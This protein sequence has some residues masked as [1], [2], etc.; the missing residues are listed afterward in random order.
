MIGFY[1]IMIAVVALSASAGYTIFTSLTAGNALSLSH[2]NV[3]LLDQ[4]LAALQHVMI[5][6]PEGDVAIPF[7]DNLNPVNPNSR[8]V[9]PSWVSGQGVTPWNIPYGYC[10]YAPTDW[11]QSPDDTGAVFSATGVSYT[12]DLKTD[13]FSLG[14]DRSYVIGGSSRPSHVQ[15]APNP[16]TVL[17]F[18][19]SP[20]AN[21]SAVPSCDSIYWTGTGWAVA[22]SPSGAVRALTKDAV[23]DSLAR[24]P[25]VMKRY[26]APVGTGSGRFPSEPISLENALR[27]FRLLSPLRMSLEFSPGSY[28]I[29]LTEIDFG[30]GAQVPTLSE[31]NAFQ[32]LKL[33][34]TG[35]VEISP[36]DAGTLSFPIDTSI[37]NIQF[38]EDILLQQGPGTRLYMSDSSAGAIHS[39]GAYITLSDS[40][41]LSPQNADPALLIEGGSA[42]I[43]GAV[44]IDMDLSG[45]D[46]LR[47]SSGNLRL[48]G[49]LFIENADRLFTQD[50]TGFFQHGPSAS[51]SIDTIPETLADYPGFLIPNLV[52]GSVT[53]GLQEENEACGTQSTCEALCPAQTR[54]LSG[55]CAANTVN[56]FL[57]SSG[58]NSDQTGY[59]CT[60]EAASGSWDPV[61]GDLDLPE[62][63]GSEARAICGPLN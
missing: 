19:I 57:V 21:Q 35:Q 17:A 38:S 59:A 18:L 10:P 5:V 27:E 28:V 62:I 1:I 61:S 56:M 15:D 48:D 4:N 23:L 7:G 11:A 6:S 20:A 30:G 60:W 14:S 12:V 16:P 50:S 34:G 47:L 42:Y 22:G 45:S 37:K 9:L 49:D 52:T 13:V 40:V 2:R 33:S 58:V 53:I 29:D 24:Q 36:Q 51:A 31:N 43:S 3:T 26:I 8:M 55:S 44:L 25:R 32:A 46:P 63:T 39:L 54:V 41:A